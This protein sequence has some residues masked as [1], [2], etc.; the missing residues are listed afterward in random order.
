MYWRGAQGSG[1]I[2]M[3]WVAL[4]VLLKASSLASIVEKCTIIE[5]N[6]AVSNSDEG[7]AVLY[8]KG[9]LR[10]VTT[11]L[12]VWLTLVVKALL[13]PCSCTVRKDNL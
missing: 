7:I 9:I 13:R 10:D 6:S 4:N 2:S 11:V 1:T 12:S 3:A 5:L 8:L